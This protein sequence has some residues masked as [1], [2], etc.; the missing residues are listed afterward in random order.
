MLIANTTRAIAGFALLALCGVSQVARCQ[1]AYPIR[2]VRFVVPYPPGG[3]TD[4][5]ARLIGTALTAK[6]SQQVV[7]DNRSGGDTIIGATLVAK[8]AP[9]GYTLLYHATTLVLLPL[10]H[11]H[12]PF[13]PLRELAPVATVALNEK[14]L[15]THPAVPANNLQ[16]LIVH[17][18]A[19]PG[20]LN[21]AM[22]ATGSANHLANE[23][24]NIAAGIRTTQVPYKGA[25]PALTDLMGGHVQMLFALPISVIQHVQRGTLRGIAISGETRL[26]ALAKVP[27]FNEAGLPKFEVSTWQ[28][29]LAPARVPRSI[30]D[31][32]SRD[33]AQALANRDMLDKFA[34]QGSLPLVSTPDQFAQMMRAETA[35]YA[36]VIKAANIRLE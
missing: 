18:R 30:V 6:W 12:M 34:A 27:T 8:A 29:I 15:V 7:V 17:A 22:T 33:V 14:L 5:M 28:G 3:S 2:P 10:L 26:A 31:R 32:L 36:Q 24:L 19:N 35:R 1:D 13:D 23:M 20:K 16:E 9:D 21:F 25:G 11:K 4:P